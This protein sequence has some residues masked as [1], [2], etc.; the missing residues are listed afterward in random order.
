MNG[1]QNYSRGAHFDPL[2][3]NKWVLLALF[4]GVVGGTSWAVDIIADH[5][6]VWAHPGWLRNLA[7]CG[8]FG[9]GY[10]LLFGTGLIRAAHQTTADVAAGIL[11]HR[12]KAR[13][14]ANERRGWQIIVAAVFGIMVLVV[15][16]PVVAWARTNLTFW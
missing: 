15:A 7:Q 11:D 14:A 13:A 3:V 10:L 9:G 16:A 5:G 12:F 2:T 4:V 1:H 6:M 8:I